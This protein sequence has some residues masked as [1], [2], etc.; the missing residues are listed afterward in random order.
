MYFPPIKISSWRYMQHQKENK[1]HRC[2]GDVVFE[3]TLDQRL[4]DVPLERFQLWSKFPQVRRDLS[5]T[6]DA[7]TPVQDLLNEIYGLQIN[8][9][10]DIVIFSIYQGDGVP[11]GLKSV[12]L[13]LILQ[14]F[15]STLT[16]QNIEQ[17]ITPLKL[18]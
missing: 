17:T 9:L 10:Q 2:L 16:E 7:G 8:E 6:V 13:G 3:L 11:S 12:S 18:L 1:Q 15:S 4:Q 14:D 5:L